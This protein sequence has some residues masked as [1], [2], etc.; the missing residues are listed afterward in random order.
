MLEKLEHGDYNASKI[1]IS[2]NRSALTAN[3]ID[4]APLKNVHAVLD[5]DNQQVALVFTGDG[6]AKARKMHNKIKVIQSD[7]SIL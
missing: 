5:S 6:H 4:V 2:L 3:Q 1:D 7:A